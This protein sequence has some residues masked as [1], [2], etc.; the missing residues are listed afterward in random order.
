LLRFFMLD[1]KYLIFQ[2]FN[3][4]NDFLVNYTLNYILNILIWCWSSAKKFA[5]RLPSIVAWWKRRL[6]CKYAF[7]NF[8][9]N[10]PH[11]KKLSQKVSDIARLNEVKG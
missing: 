3:F 4:L 2:V 6:T 8:L 11:I 10:F 1:F 9:T 5:A 7:R